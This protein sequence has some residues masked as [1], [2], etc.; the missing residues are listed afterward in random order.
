MKR[1]TTAHDCPGFGHIPAGSLWADDSPYITDANAEHF[2]DVDAE[3]APKAK[4]PAKS[5]KAAFVN[6]VEYGPEGDD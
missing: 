3:P 5:V 1:C 6:L 4:K 2:A